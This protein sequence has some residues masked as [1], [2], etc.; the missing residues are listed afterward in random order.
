MTSRIAFRRYHK[1]R[2]CFFSETAPA[3]LP[4]PSAAPPPRPASPLA[5]PPA[6]PVLMS[7][8]WRRRDIEEWAEI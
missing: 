8:G 5:F 7:K 4:A 6:P 3:P 1:H 2:T